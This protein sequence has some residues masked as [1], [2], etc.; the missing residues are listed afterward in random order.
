MTKLEP[1]SLQKDQ[2]PTWG[3]S[4]PA[5]VKV[6][7]KVK[8]FTSFSIFSKSEAKTIREKFDDV[9]QSSLAEADI[10]LADSLEKYQPASLPTSNVIESYPTSIQTPINTTYQPLK[11]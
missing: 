3:K 2:R 5:S 10:R 1:N 8:C 9:D 7:Q 6:N 11:V 4:Y